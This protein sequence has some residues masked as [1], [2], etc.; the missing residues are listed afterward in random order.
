MEKEWQD[1]I[2]AKL[3][4]KDERFRTFETEKESLKKEEQGMSIH[5]IKIK[6]ITQ[7]QKNYLNRF[8]EHKAKKN[9]IINLHRDGIK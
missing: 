5:E 3:R 6:K 2:A 9:M 4:Q 7:D 8:V 1:K